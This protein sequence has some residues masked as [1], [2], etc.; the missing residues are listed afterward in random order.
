MWT[1]SFTCFTA[2]IFVVNFNMVTRINYFTQMHA[3]TLLIC[4]LLPYEVYMWVSNYMS[5]EVSK[6][7][8]AVMEAHLSPIFYLRVAACLAICLSLD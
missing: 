4:S 1:A 8:F 5:P 6:V 7:Q 3:F 2:L